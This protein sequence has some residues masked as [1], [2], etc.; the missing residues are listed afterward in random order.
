MLKFSHGE[1]TE[2]IRETVRQ[3]A[4]TEIA[5]YAQEIDRE[6][7]FPVG[8]WPKLGA[9]GLLGITV[10]AEDGG[11]GLGYLDHVIAMEELSRA[12][13]SVGLSYAAHANLCVNQI[14]LFG[15]S[16]QK[17]RYLPKLMT[18][19]HVGALAMS[20]EGAGSD[21]VSMRLRA[22]DKGNHF[23][24]NG[25]KMWITNGPTADVFVVY[26]RTTPDAGS[27][28][29]TAFIVERG[30]T[31][32][33]SAQ[34]LD[35]LGMRGSHT[36]ELVFKDCCVPKE[37][38]LGALNAGVKVLMEGL[39]YE[40]VILAGGPLGIMRACLDTVLPYMRE[41]EQFGK[42]IGEFQLIQAKVADIYTEMN[43]AR[44]L[45]YA[46][47]Q[48]CDRG[49]ANGADTAGAFLFAAERATHAALT[50]IQCLGGNGYT[51]EYPTGRLLRDAKLYE[52]AGGTSEIR[53][54][55]I[56][57]ALYRQG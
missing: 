50:A 1:I 5:P 20:E 13:A 34:E 33:S 22:E 4:A 51:N 36:S 24:L 14:R 11:S 6:S 16:E 40:R 26:A 21:I 12:S 41:R 49:E 18:G 37:N 44:A 8:L 56:G 54:I 57:R 25:S 10:E 35:K 23:I 53:R 39:N 30:F 55:I 31:G 19:E 7:R 47:A 17:N 46:V 9:L 29:L 43:A 15:T 3:F 42:K 45:V 48:A 52:I 2:C 27:K 38:I 28:G 32:F